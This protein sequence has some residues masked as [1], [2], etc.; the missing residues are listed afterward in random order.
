MSGCTQVI[1]GLAAVSLLVQAYVGVRV[2]PNNWDSMAYHLSRAAYWIQYHS[3]AQFPGASIR[4]A[5]S[6]PDGEVLQGLTMMISETDRWAQSVQWLALVGIALTVFSGARL[7]RFGSDESIFAACL[8]VLLPQ[9]LM[10]SSSTQ[11]DLIE[12]FFVV[13]TAFFAVRGLRDR[14]RGDMV[15]A[16]L[17]LGLAVGTKGTALIAGA[18]LAVLLV[19]AVVAYRPPDRFVLMSATGA[20]VAIFALASYNYVLNVQHRGSLFGGVQDQTRLGVLARK[21]YSSQLEILQTHRASKSTGLI[22]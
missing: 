12:A 8:F 1:V 22:D 14:A 21:T 17:A 2:A 3:F 6:A 13:A 5:A 11:N 15:V 19:A 16:A 20:L 10:Q 7:L 4:Q 18:A 9:P